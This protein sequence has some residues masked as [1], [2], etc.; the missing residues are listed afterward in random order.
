MK[1]LILFAG[2]LLAGCA[3]SMPPTSEFHTPTGSLQSAP[4]GNEAPKTPRTL[5][6]ADVEFVQTI[7]KRKLKDPDSAKFEGLEGWTTTTGHAFVCGWVNAKNGFGGYTGR[8]PFMASLTRSTASSS[9]DVVAKD[10]LDL[11]LLRAA[12]P[13]LATTI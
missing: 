13:N 4:N 11:M 9:L 12:C 3:A 2:L 10:S 7:I 6:K 8:K 5:S 1:P